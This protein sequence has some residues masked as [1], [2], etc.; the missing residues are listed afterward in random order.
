MKGY[1]LAIFLM[2][3]AI[4]NVFAKAQTKYKFNSTNLRISI[5][6]RNPQ[7]IAAF[8]EGR[9]FSKAM[10]AQ[11]AQSCFMTIGIHNKSNKVLWHDLETWT[12]TRN[13]KIIKPFNRKYWKTMWLKMGISQAHQSTFRWT[14]LP[15]ALDFRSNEHEGGNIILP[16]SKHA[17]TLNATFKTLKDKS[18]K[19]IHVKIENIK[20]LR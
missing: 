13:N 3:A 9:G 19:P 2:L 4:S 20:C 7:Q 1:L 18:G 16:Y 5:L 12:F 11:L 17:Y 14:L 15:E 10:I 8:Y 6:L